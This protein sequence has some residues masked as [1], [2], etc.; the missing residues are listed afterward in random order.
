MIKQAIGMVVVGENLTL[1]EMEQTMTAIMGGEAT[2]AQI[3]SFITALRIKG[4]TIEEVGAAAKVMRAVATRIDARADRVLDTC[5]T[6]GDD[7]GTFNISTTAALV[8]AGASVTVAKHGNRSVSSKSGSADVLEALGVNLDVPP[9]IVEEAVND[10]GIGFL[11]A[12]KMHPAMK[13]AIGPRK[14]IGIR[15][16]FNMLGPLTNPAGANCQLLGVYSP[17]LVETFAGVLKELGCS[18][19]MIVHGADGMDEI[20]LTGETRVAELKEGAITA[21]N[22]SPMQFGLE[23]CSAEDLSGG[24]PEQNA[25]ITKAILAG[26]GGPR[27]DI[28]LLNAGAAIYV[29]GAAETIEA[30][31]GRAAESIDSGSAAAKLQA[32]ID[33]TN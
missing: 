19:A 11:F 3:A 27:R 7:A 1:D 10:V 26:E 5:G 30:G 6:G 21:Y 13:Y 32:L 25:E 22:L 16:V 8:A 18:H 14:E 12:P 31:I 2:P 23:A 9:E 15:T 29:A 20:T 33:I 17:L 28:T 4:E 24:D